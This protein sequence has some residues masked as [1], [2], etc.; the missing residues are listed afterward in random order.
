MSQRLAT[1]V[2]ELR[3]EETRI[4]ADLDGLRRQVKS[5]EAQLK[6][7]Q[8]ALSVLDNKP[9]SKSGNRKPAATR[10]EVIAAMTDAINTNGP[11]D[12]AELKRLVA[13]KMASVGKSRSG[14]AL[15][16]KEVLKDGHFISS[17]DGLITKDGTPA[18]TRSR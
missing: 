6:Q 7:I 16:F 10:Q 15:R 18:P 5:G 12:E 2:D 13:H 9:R 11:V 14:L 4:Q 17:E 3:A 1:A 8:R